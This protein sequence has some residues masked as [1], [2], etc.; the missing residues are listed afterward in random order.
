MINLKD[1]I[2]KKVLVPCFTALYHKFTEPVIL[3]IAGYQILDYAIMNLCWS[4]EYN[5]N[6]A[7]DAD[8]PTAYMVLKVVKLKIFRVS[9]C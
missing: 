3:G 8:I 1:D 6:Q 4:I 9:V 7:S 5:T 2:A